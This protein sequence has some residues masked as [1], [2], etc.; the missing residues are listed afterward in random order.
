MKEIF[1]RRSVR[2]YSDKKISEEI[3][4]RIIEAGVQSPSARNQEPW[5]F[6]LITD[7]EIIAKLSQTS[8]N[9]VFIDKANAIIC[10]VSKPLD[11]LSTPGMM[12]QDMGIA[13]ENMM[14]EA[15]FHEI[16]S[17]YIGIYPNEERIAYLHETLSI[18]SDYIPFS[19]LALGYPKKEDAF[20][21]AK[22]DY[23]SKI[24]K[25]RF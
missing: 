3:L 15:R 5:E 1:T 8:K 17:C 9:S 16:G 18:P 25:E 22:R 21:E 23:L 13:M 24:H 14:I 11:S 6:V 4:Y 2:E 19:L 10:V 20:K 12:P 7:K